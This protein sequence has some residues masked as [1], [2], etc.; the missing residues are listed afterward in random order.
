[1]KKHLGLKYVYEDVGEETVPVKSKVKI[2]P[3]QLAKLPADLLSQLYKVALELNQEQALAL[4]EKIKPIDAHIAYELDVLVR[5][6]LFDT[7]QDLIKK[8][9][10]ST[11]EDIHD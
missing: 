10:Q 5:N 3:E 1:M 7:L 9:E 4:I 8:S 2:G 11:S 6:F